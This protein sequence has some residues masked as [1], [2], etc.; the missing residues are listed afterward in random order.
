MKVCKAKI[1]EKQFETNAS[2]T[3]SWEEVECQG[4]CVNAPM[5]MIFRDTYEDLRPERLE[6]IIDAFEAGKGSTIK[7]GPQI[8]RHFSAPVGGPITLTEKPA[9]KSLR[10]NGAAKA[11]STTAARKPAAKKADA[12]ASD[13]PSLDDKNRPPVMKKPKSP[14][15]LKQISGVGPKLETVLNGLGIFTFAQ[16]SKWKKAER[17]WVD[18][19]LKFKGRIDRD[20]WV[21]QAKALAKSAKA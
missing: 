3:L 18:G 6:E 8:D 12:P 17:D 16:I 4:A 13:T 9:V 20:D 19:Y 1:N 14:D 15:D 5:V 11:K 10:A 2:G 7:P 21:K